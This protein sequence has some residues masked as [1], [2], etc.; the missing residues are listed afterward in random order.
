M[1]LC[2]SLPNRPFVLESYFD[3]MPLFILLSELS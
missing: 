2:I 1:I 3:K